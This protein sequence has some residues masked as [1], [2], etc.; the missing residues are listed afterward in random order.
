MEDSSTIK[1]KSGEM[2]LEIEGNDY[3]SIKPEVG[4]EFKYR[5]YIAYNNI[6][7]DIGT[8]L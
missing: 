5:Q 8:W 6:C 2:R 7:N 3:Y 1:E 4:I